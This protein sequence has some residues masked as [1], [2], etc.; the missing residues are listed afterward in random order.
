MAAAAQE[1]QHPSEC[2]GIRV[3]KQML[4]TWDDSISV[5]P[6]LNTTGELR[7]W[8][9]TKRTQRRSER[10]AAHVESDGV[11]HHANDMEGG[12]RADSWNA[13]VAADGRGHECRGAADSREPSQPV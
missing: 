12:R 8:C 4:I 6:F 1:V 7:A 11:R 2:L 10:C 3:D 13:L 9:R 5:N